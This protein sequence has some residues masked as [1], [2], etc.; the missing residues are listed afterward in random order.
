MAG[1]ERHEGSWWDHWV[2]WLTERSGE[3]ITAPRSVGSRLFPSK[4]PAP[5][6]DVHL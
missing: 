5:G 3:Q 1:A 4:E 6:T 2:G